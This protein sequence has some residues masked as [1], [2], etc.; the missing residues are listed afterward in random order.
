[1]SYLHNSNV[2]V[3]K[4][5]KSCKFALSLNIK[6]LIKFCLYLNINL[7][8]TIAFKCYMTYLFQISTQSNVKIIIIYDVKHLDLVFSKTVDS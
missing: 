8:W 5:A 6:V 7:N 4:T 3:N 1:M 2:I